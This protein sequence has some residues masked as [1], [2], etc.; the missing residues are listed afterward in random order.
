MVRDQP[1]ILLTPTQLSGPCCVHLDECDNEVALSK[2]GTVADRRR[3][4]SGRH[5]TGRRRAHR[6]RRAQTV[7]IALAVAGVCLVSICLL[8][9]RPLRVATGSTSDIRQE[10]ADRTPSAAALTR[11]DGIGRSGSRGVPGVGLQ[12]GSPATAVHITVT[13]SSSSSA[14]AAPRPAKPAVAVSRRQDGPA[15][16]SSVSLAFTGDVLGHRSVLEQAHVDAH[17]SVVGGGYTFAE[18]LEGIAPVVSSVDWAICHQETVIGG[19]SDTDAMGYPSFRAPHALAVDQKSAGWDACDTASNHTT[20]HGQEGIDT[21]LRALDDA[22]ILHTGSYRSEAE[23]LQLTIYRVNGVRIGHIAVTYGLNNGAP[24][25]PWSVNLVD[26]P[27]IASQ[28]RQ[29]KKAGADI[30]L[31]SIHAGVEQ[32]QEPSG[33][34]ERW[35]AA[36]MQSPDVDLLVGAHAHVVQPIRR[37]DDGRY[38]VYGLGNLLALQSKAFDAPP[39]RD[40]IVVMPTFTRGADGRYRVSRMGY[41]PTFIRLTEGTIRV[42]LAPGPYRERVRQIVDQYGADAIDL[43][44][45]FN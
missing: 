44:D 34:Q 19:P 15:K 8:G 20:D 3:H 9:G 25:H 6:G 43:T 4:S 12:I 26:V 33:D 7:T 45:R 13:R 21:T 16:A 41:V 30:V 28:A 11:S 40:G 18:M 10:A 42:T 39:N 24:P 14:G 17:G 22:G 1:P 32:Q 2:G 38:V 29:L 36:I 23:A 27:R 31:V 37:L 35:D 5:H